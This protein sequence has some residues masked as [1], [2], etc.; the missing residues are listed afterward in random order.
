MIR[1]GNLWKD[2][3][4]LVYG[5][6]GKKRFSPPSAP[7]VPSRSLGNSSFNK[8]LQGTFFIFPHF[9]ALFC[10]LG[11]PYVSRGPGLNEGYRVIGADRGAVSTSIAALYVY[12]GSFINN[13]GVEL[14]SLSADT[15]ART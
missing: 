15:A 4:P 2:I 5:C 6:R 8:S 10:C 7:R 13:N 3:K 14:A 11:C 9:I 12:R 1:S